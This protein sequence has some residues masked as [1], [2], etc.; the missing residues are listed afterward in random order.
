M[1]TSNGDMRRHTEKRG[2][3]KTSTLV[4][5]LGIFLGVVGVSLL[6]G[7]GIGYVG[8]YMEVQ[9]MRSGSCAVTLAVHEEPLVTCA[10]GRGSC[11][12]KYPCLKMLVN[13]TV[14]TEQ[15]PEGRVPGVS[16][17]DTESESLPFVTSDNQEQVTIHNVTLYDSYETFLLQYDTRKVRL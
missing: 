10:C 9:N 16:D 2:W 8:P 7:F 14:E 6:L 1:D 15:L 3:I 4:L 13:M 5:G 12:S 17:N 11:Q